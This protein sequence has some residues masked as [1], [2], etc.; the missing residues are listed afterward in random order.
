MCL[1][2][3]RSL[4]LTE[5]I[6]CSDINIK[7][8]WPNTTANWKIRLTFTQAGETNWA[9]Q[10][11]TLIVGHVIPGSP[12]DP[13]TRHTASVSTFNVLPDWTT[14][15]YL[16][17]WEERDV[18]SQPDVDWAATSV[19]NDARNLNFV[20][21]D[22][23]METAA[24]KFNLTR[25]MRSRI[26]MHTNIAASILIAKVKTLTRGLGLRFD[27]WPFNL[28]VS[29]CRVPTNHVLSVYRLWCW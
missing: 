28:K 13:L 3:N 18:R 22:A 10:T 29:A 12:D 23:A 27:L 19:I 24:P 2:V 5:V 8:R 7:L 20:D 25:E 21:D 16:S 6:L 4:S 11:K 17:S 14:A 9:W 26:D 1:S 15:T